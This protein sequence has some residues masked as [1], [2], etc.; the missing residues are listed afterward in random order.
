MNAHHKMQGFVQF[1]LGLLHQINH[2]RVNSRHKTAFLREGRK[3]TDSWRH[4]QYDYGLRVRKRGF[5]DIFEALISM[6]K[7][8]KNLHE[9][10]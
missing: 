5:H 10:R 6:L 3:R 8:K 9:W 1:V 4:R 2:F 7:K